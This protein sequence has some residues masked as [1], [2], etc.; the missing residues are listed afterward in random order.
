MK[1][2]MNLF[3]AHNQWSTRPE[4]ERFSTLEEMYAA[5]R[6]YADNAA[7]ALA[8]FRSLRVE[9]QNGEVVL[10]GRTQKMSFTHHAF[11]QL[12][13]R[14]K[15]KDVRGNLADYFRALPAT[16][17]VQNLNYLLANRSERASENASMLFHRNGSVMVRAF[18]TEQYERIWNYEIV[19][20]LIALR[21]TQGW[22]VP[23][24]RPAH[25]GAPGS[26]VATAEDCLSS[27]LIKPGDWISPAGLY[28]SDHDMFAFM[29]NEDIRL[30]DGTDEGLSRGFFV[31]NGEVGDVGLWLM[32]FY[33]EYVC[34]NHIV[35]NA[36]PIA[37]VSVKHVGGVRGQLG[38][39]GIELKK[40]A[41][42]SAREDQRKVEEAR[43]LVLGA[44][45]ADVL[46][47]LFKLKVP[48]L[49]KKR[50]EAAY[51]TAEMYADTHGNPRSLWGMVQGL[52]RLSQNTN[53]TD[54][55]N[56]IDRAVPK[57]LAL[58]K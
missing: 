56:A 47:A 9:A 27:S 25:A 30:D 18:L 6:S 20:R 46:D 54:D 4:D 1:S 5:T 36:K 14:V 16:L 34:G 42:A 12:A 51:D 21:D 48:E 3:H 19:E 26:R 37:E 10:A 15:P 35:W 57:M 52:T 23:P 11:G 29:V 55:R 2:G 22:Q 33:Y 43:R 28:A 32:S 7:T 50:I 38:G 58:V 53:F 44:S 41:D 39:W 45:K 49:T 8:P 31:R 17:A 24:A 40:Y 13:E